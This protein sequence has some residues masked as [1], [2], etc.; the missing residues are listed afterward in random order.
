MLRSL[1]D[2]VTKKLTKR[3]P[4]APKVEQHCQP[5]SGSVGVES[6]SSVLG[7]IGEL[8]KKVDILQT[9]PSEMPH[10][11][12]EL[13]T[14]A[15]RRV[16]ALEAELIATKKVIFYYHHYALAFHLAILVLNRYLSNFLEFSSCIL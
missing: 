15:M 3:T 11:K 6:G 1:P 7:R 14:A 16:D 12:E 8:E 10:E 5:T 2:N 13:L 4:E 9:K